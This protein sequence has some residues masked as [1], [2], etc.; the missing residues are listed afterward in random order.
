MNIREFSLL[1]LCKQERY[2]P[3]D[4]ALKLG[5]TFRETKNIWIARRTVECRHVPEWI[6]R[7]DADSSTYT[8]SLK[9]FEFN[10]SFCIIL[11]GNVY[12]DL[13]WSDS[14]FDSIIPK[15]PGTPQIWELME[16]VE[17]IFTSSKYAKEITNKI[18]SKI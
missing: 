15:G 6:L 1:Q 4:L 16:M 10:G 7:I 8:V 3:S 13:V 14:M 5:F 9:S 11:S 2:V 18:I 12:G 17:N